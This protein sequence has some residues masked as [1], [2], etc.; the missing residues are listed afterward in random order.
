[1]SVRLTRTLG[2]D[3]SPEQSSARPENV[4]FGVGKTPR[5]ALWSGAYCNNAI[6]AYGA[7]PEVIFETVRRAARLSSIQ[8]KTRMTAKE[9][10][11][12]PKP[13]YKEFGFREDGQTVLYDL[14]G[15][16]RDSSYRLEKAY[17][18]FKYRKPK[19]FLHLLTDL[20]EFRLLI[21][22]H[23]THLPYGAVHRKTVLAFVHLN[24]ESVDIL[25]TN[26]K[27]RQLLTD[28]F[29]NGKHERLSLLLLI[30]DPEKLPKDLLRASD[31]NWFVGAKNEQFA[32]KF[33]KL[34]T[35]RKH[36]G[37][38]HIGVMWDRMMP[39]TLRSFTFLVNE[40]DDWLIEKKSVLKEQDEDWWDYLNKLK[41]ERRD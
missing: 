24:D 15:T 13:Q 33:Y 39:E 7:R 18:G 41:E 28:I 36:F 35:Y 3:T 26:E 17:K 21:Q 40:K 1:M 22:D 11:R 14:D 4:N 25:R 10:D 5:L 8:F 16:F 6:F 38:T 12:R 32:E 34:P 27:A 30:D 23:Y 37:L 29:L 9:S 2:F 31:L 19:S 20:Q